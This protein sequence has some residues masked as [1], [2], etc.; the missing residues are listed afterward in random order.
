MRRKD[1]G[2]TSGCKFTLDLLHE[3][4]GAVAWK[5]QGAVQRL[6]AACA[7]PPKSMW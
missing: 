4:R 1:F 6:E 3:S 5:G 2:P 7:F